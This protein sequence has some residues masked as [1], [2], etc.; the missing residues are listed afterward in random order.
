MEDKALSLLPSLWRSSIPASAGR[1]PFHSLHNEM[2]RLF[3]QFG[4]GLPAAWTNSGLMAPTID[5]SESDSELTVTAELPGV[6]EEDMHL[7]LE[8][9]VLTIQGEKRAEEKKDDEEKKYHLVER[10][11]GSFQRSIPLSFNADP[12]SIKAKFENGV[13]N[14]TIPKP[15]EA[16]QKS[17][18]IPIT[19]G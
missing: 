18:R 19:K 6:A 12:D 17:S 8:D 11:Y 4:S 5:V 15:P 2:N 14:V 3:E 9:N 1:D 13:L 7:S 10:S 16:A